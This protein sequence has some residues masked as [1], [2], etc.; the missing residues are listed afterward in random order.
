MRSRPICSLIVALRGLPQF[1]SLFKNAKNET[2]SIFVNEIYQ[3]KNT[4]DKR[5]HKY[6]WSVSFQ[7]NILTFQI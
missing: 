7:A 4:T 1:Y 3:K 2:T 6:S 5:E